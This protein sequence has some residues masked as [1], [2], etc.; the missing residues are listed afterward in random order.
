MEFNDSLGSRGR[1]EL[2]LRVRKGGGIA[3]EQSGDGGSGCR[4]LTRWCWLGDLEIW[5]E[6]AG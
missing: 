5:P 3:A 4:G 1:V 6:C 2:W